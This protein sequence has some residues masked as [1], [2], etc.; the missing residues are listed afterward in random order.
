MAG[1]TCPACGQTSRNV[2]ESRRLH[3]RVRRRCSCSACGKR[4]TTWELRYDKLFTG[5][6]IGATS[7]V[8][9]EQCTHWAGRCGLGFPDPEEEEGIGFAQECVSFMERKA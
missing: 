9:C 4:Y 2:I 7:P 6:M 3:D 8:T 5:M 1:I